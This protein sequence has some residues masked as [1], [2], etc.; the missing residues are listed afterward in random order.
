LIVSLFGMTNTAPA[1][2]DQTSWCAAFVNFCL[3]AAGRTGTFSALSGSFRNFGKATSNPEA[4]DIVV[5]SAHGE[6]GKKGFGHV[7]FFVKN[8]GEKIVVLG[9]NQGG[10]SNSTGAVTEI[11]F[12]REGTSLVLHSFRKI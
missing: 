10:K 8:E 1:E 2:G 4:G 5:F 3:Y 11:A 6:R 7:G 12:P 9:G